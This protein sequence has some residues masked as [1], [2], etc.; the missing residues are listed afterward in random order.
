MAN[1]NPKFTEE[2][3]Q[4]FIDHAE[5]GETVKGYEYENVTENGYDN[6][7][8]VTCRLILRNVKTGTLI[9]GDYAYDPGEGFI[10][11]FPTKYKAVERKEK[12]VTV[13]YYE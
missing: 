9:A 2:E 4:T 11:E 13:V 7:G 6:H 3:I 5:A 12:T 1:K 8:S 10:V